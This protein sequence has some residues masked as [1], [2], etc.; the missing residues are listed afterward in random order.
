MYCFS[1]WKNSYL[2]ASMENRPDLPLLTFYW[3]KFY[4]SPCINYLQWRYS[5]PVRKTISN[6]EALTQYLW[7]YS[8]PVRNIVSIGEA[9]LQYPWGRS[10]VPVR[11]IRSTCE[12]IQYLWRTIVSIRE[13]YPQYP[14]GRWS[15]PVRNICINTLKCCPSNNVFAD[16]FCQKLW[17]IVK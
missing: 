14:W 13:A 15:V 10:S 3:L 2:W 12:V 8:V 17:E 9:Y 5:V 4:L 1:P 11:H 6:R 7:G 16:P